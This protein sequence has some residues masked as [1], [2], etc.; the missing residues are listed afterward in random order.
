MNNVVRILRM[1]LIAAFAWLL[2]VGASLTWNIQVIRQQIIT[3]ADTEA[4]SALKRDLAF[5]LWSTNHGG[6]YLKVGKDTQPSPYL[7]HIPDRDIPTPNGGMLTLQ[8]P[9]ASLREIK[10]KQNELFG[11]LA[12]I[13]GRLY[14]NPANAPDEWELKALSVVEQ[15]REDYSEVANIDGRPYLRRMQP[16]WMENGCLK[17]HAWTAIPVGGLRGGTDVSIPLDEYI[18]AGEKSE[19]ATSITHGVILL[20]GWMAIVASTQ[21]ARK[22]ALVDKRLHD[23]LEHLSRIDGLTNL[24]NRRY[25]LELA[26][27]EV[28]RTT[29]YAIPLAAIMVD[30]DLFKSV[31]D[32]YG[33]EVGDIVLRE[34]AATLKTTAREVDLVCRYGG[35]EFVILLPETS[36]ANAL[37]AAERL[38]QAVAALEIP[39]TGSAPIRVTISAGVAVF[40][41]EENPNIDTLLRD[42]DCALYEAKH[43]GRNRVVAYRR[44]QP[45][46]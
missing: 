27:Q 5:R 40:D 32:G 36:K 41:E 25:F 12:R 42:A 18:A 4:K 38:R 9:A 14:L 17:C 2:A 3:L 21:R 46:T 11:E 24:L 15:T 10:S 1:A 45:S 20:V 28:S 33:H 29:R 31:N 43:T 23:E 8:N 19:Q 16:M 35:E 44:Q 37:E 30:V 34:I 6:I 22:R 7:S 13:T 39:L 26:N